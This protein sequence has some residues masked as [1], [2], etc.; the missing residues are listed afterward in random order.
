MENKFYKAENKGVTMLKSGLFEAEPL[1]RHCFSTRLGGVSE[2][3]LSSLNL[4]FNRGD[5]RENVLTNY[6]RLCDAAGLYY[7]RLTRTAQE[8]GINVTKITEQNVGTGFILPPFCNTDALI[9]NLP[10]TPVLCQ[11]ADCVPILLYDRRK[12]AVAAIHA[13]WR[14][15][16]DGVIEETVCAMG[17]E[18]QSDPDDMIAA[19]GACI[20]PCC[21][22][23]DEDVAEKFVSEFGAL[24]VIR[25]N[26]KPH[27]D[28]F[29][30]ARDALTG[31]GISERRI[32]CSCECTKCNPSFYYSHRY[33]GYERGSLAS[34]IAV[35]GDKSPQIYLK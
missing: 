10:D 18:Y 11:T 22:E 6:R 24:S 4:G 32:D 2:G 31:C 17:I 9:T 19:I 30:C 25:G 29:R 28:L 34:I 26:G 8:H 21:F 33:S 1:L 16:I 27:V 15:M 35:A 12:H 3:A 23:V 20:G 7:P 14:G 5:E 13:G